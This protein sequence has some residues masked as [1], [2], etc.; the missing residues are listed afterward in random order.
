MRHISDGDVHRRLQDSC[1]DLFVTLTLNI[2]D[3][4]SN[5]D[6]KKSTWPTLLVVDEILVRRHFS[7]KNIILAGVW[8][9]PKNL[10]RTYMEL[11]LKTLLNELV[12]L[13]DGNAFFIPSYSSSSSNQL[14]RIQVY[15]TGAYFDKPAQALV[16]NLPE[17]I[18]AFGFGRCEL[19]GRFSV[20]SYF[21]V[22]MRK[23]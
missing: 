4:Q 22:P 6:S 23:K 2:D 13:E 10:S 19:E 16:Q 1:S 17:P 11:F 9:G 8:P 21:S 15:L 20:Y 12:R 7:P 3:I 14:M 5:K 18:A